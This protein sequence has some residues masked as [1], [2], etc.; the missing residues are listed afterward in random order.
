MNFFTSEEVPPWLPPPARE[1]RSYAF[2]AQIVALIEIP[3]SVV[4]SI[5]SFYYYFKFSAPG[6]VI[7]NP[8]A[9]AYSTS[10]LWLSVYF[11]AVIFVSILE[12]SFIKAHVSS[13][14]DTG[15][16]VPAEE[17]AIIWGIVSILFG[18]LPGIFLIACAYRL[19]AMNSEMPQSAMQSVG[20]QTD[21]HTTAK[22]E[23]PQ[24]WHPQKQEQQTRPQQ[25][26]VPAATTTPR[27]HT[28]MVK[29]KK[30]GAS[31]PAFMHACPNCN[32]P[33]S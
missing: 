3:I 14:I 5:V 33:K 30:C 8:N 31:Y 12:I 19:R 17:R 10:Y 4:L 1:A 25:Y 2:W 24:Q 29:C 7:V 6:Y 22:Q 9:A 21:V 11:L 23:V 16:F 27:H 15:K 18:F 32:E 13:L 28:D 26:N 20:S